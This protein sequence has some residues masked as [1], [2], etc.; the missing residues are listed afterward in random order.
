MNY[1]EASREWGARKLAEGGY[2]RSHPWH[3]G[4]SPSPGLDTIDRTTI[5]IEY[6]DDGGCGSTLTGSWHDFGVLVKGTADGRTY[7][8]FVGDPFTQVVSEIADV[9]QRAEKKREAGQ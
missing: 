8:M 1:D 5:T 6:E 2:D 7:E 9:A 3:L 4:R